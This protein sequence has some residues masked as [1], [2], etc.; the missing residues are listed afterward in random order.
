[1]VTAALDIPPLA[2]PPAPR[3]RPIDLAAIDGVPLA[4][5][6]FPP[7]GRPRGGALIV[8]AMGVPQTFYEPFAAW[9]AA[10]GLHVMTFDY[11]GTGQSR[12]GPLR[13]LDAD[14][15]TWARLD[16]TAVVRAVQDL[17]GELPITWIGHSLGGQIMP[18]VPDH[19]ELAKV[20]TVA[21]GSGY[22][23]E[24]APQL[25]RRAW[26]LWW[27]FAPL[28][29]P[30]FGYFP[31]RR[32]GMVG[33]LPRGVIRQW[34]RWSLDPEYAV[35]AEGP[36]VRALF[37][38]LRTPIT[39]LAFTDDEMMSERNTSSLHAGFTGAAVTLRRIAPADVGV[40]RIGHF[41]MF[42]PAMRE[43]VW[44]R[45]VRPELALR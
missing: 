10:L 7:I 21:T 32:L 42:R 19:R 25:R 14:V 41:G 18:F 1:M 43:P 30:L 11:R 27:G 4:A 40:A 22:W 28:L 13:G 16:T 38:A 17:V 39:S 23:K 12:R 34:R 5:R 24:N 15:V 44:E 2:P 8:P 3:Y 36:Q 37:A 33:D 26:L 31:G 20:I 6:V 9:L 35:G 45:V 29:T